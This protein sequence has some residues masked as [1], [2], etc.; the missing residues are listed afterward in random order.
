MRGLK[1][2]FKLILQ[3]VIAE[4]YIVEIMNFKEWNLKDL[5]N[6]YLLEV[7]EKNLVRD[8]LTYLTNLS[9]DK[10]YPLTQKGFIYKFHQG[11]DITAINNTLKFKPIYH[12]QLMNFPLKSTNFIDDFLTDVAEII[13]NNENLCSLV[14][15]FIFEEDFFDEE[16]KYEQRKIMLLTRIFQSIHQSVLK[17]QKLKGLFIIFDYNNGI[18]YKVD[19]PNEINS[20]LI[21]IIE[22]SHSLL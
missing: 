14:I 12:C 4:T 20:L 2:T 10:I 13:E 11:D 15:S 6:N 8:I 18:G 9:F 7:V 16:F 1:N 21:K 5:F 22:D 17:Y 19:I 3:E